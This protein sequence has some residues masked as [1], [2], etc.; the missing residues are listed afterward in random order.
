M[1]AGAIVRGRRALRT[2]RS[3][4]TLDVRYQRA[5]IV[6]LLVLVL[7]GGGGY[8]GRRGTSLRFPIHRFATPTDGTDVSIV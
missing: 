5:D 4:P 7:A 6:I 2:T 1:A 3:C 8:Y